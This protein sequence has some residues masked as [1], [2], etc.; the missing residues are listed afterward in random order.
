MADF[1]THIATSTLLGLGYGAGAHYWFDVP[2]TTSVLAG[3]LCAVSGMLPDLD[4]GPGRPLRESMAFAAAVV[5]MMLIDRF[6]QLGLGTE[7]IVLAGAGVYLTIRFGLAAL[8]RRYTTHRGMFHSLPAALIAGEVAFLLVS[9]DVR[10][11]LYKA[12][13]VVLGY[14]SHLVLDEL[15]SI[16]WYRGRIRFKQ[17]F[18]TGLK[19]LGH[20][21]WPNVSTYAKLALLTWVVVQEPGWMDR[22]RQQRQALQA[23][24]PAA[25]AEHHSTPG[26]PATSPSSHPGESPVA[27]IT[28]K[29]SEWFE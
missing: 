16:E 7:M 17:S 4:S 3:G 29:I 11:R 9:G 1:K 8:L 19:V 12:G 2:V 21:W 22:V 20:H 13:A 15:Y 26:Q 28:R 23:G 10:L 27:E 18:G 6:E 25:S 14:V 5:S 24:Q